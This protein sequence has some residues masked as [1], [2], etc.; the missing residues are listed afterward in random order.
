MK[1]TLSKHRVQID[2]T[3]I[4]WNAYEFLNSK[5][6]QENVLSQLPSTALNLKESTLPHHITN[7]IMSR[8]KTKTT[9]TTKRA[10]S[11]HLMLKLTIAALVLSNLAVLGIKIKRHSD[12]EHALHTHHEQRILETKQQRLSQQQNK[13]FNTSL[14]HVLQTLYGASLPLLSL[15]YSNKRITLTIPT[16][17]TTQWAHYIQ[18]HHPQLIE[19]ATTLK[20]ATATKISIPYDT[21]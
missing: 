15:T 5:T 8:F 13:A 16:G 3:T 17:S 4:V 6:A 21:Y 20:H 14:S 19:K 9:V 7:V 12:Y 1:L 11:T 2:N 18:K 10:I